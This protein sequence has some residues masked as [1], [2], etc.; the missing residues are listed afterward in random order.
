M[1]ESNIVEARVKSAL[2]K[3]I[4]VS[5]LDQLNAAPKYP[6]DGTSSPPKDRLEE[7]VRWVKNGR[8]D[9]ID[10]SFSFNLNAGAIQ[11]VRYMLE[12]K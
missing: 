2:Q 7:I 11:L 3:L 8:T 5:V 10:L 12:D 9:S 6:D 1:S 4:T